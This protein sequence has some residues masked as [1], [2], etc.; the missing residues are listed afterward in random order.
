MDK[1]EVVFNK[2]AGKGEVIQQVLSTGLIGALGYHGYKS[3]TKGESAGKGIAKAFQWSAPVAGAAAALATP[4]LLR[5]NPLVGREGAKQMLK[6]YPIATRGGA[7]FG[8]AASMAANAPIGHGIGRLFGD[9][10]KK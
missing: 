9:S 2:R 6:D 5:K 10:P 3:K 1:A 4:Y 7:A 8:A